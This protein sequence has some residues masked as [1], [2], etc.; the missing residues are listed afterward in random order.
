MKILYFFGVIISIIQAVFGLVGYNFEDNLSKLR[1]IAENGEMSLR[2][3]K[4]GERIAI[5]FSLYVDFNRYSDLVPFFDFRN[6]YEE[7]PFIHVY[8]KKCSIPTRGTRFQSNQLGVD[9]FVN[10]T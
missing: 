5:C 3:E 10:K 2:L 4:I 8:G 1:F 9:W 7:T 6:A